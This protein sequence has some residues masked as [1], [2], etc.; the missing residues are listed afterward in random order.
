[1]D[2]GNHPGSARLEFDVLR[3]LEPAGVIVPV[4]DFALKGDSNRHLRRGRWRWR[5]LATGRKQKE[6][7]DFE[8]EFHGNPLCCVAEAAGDQP[9]QPPAT[10]YATYKDRSAACSM[11]RTTSEGFDT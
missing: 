3:R 2:A 10:I 9:G 6:N 8:A 5:F 1:M 7:C 11:R 4:S